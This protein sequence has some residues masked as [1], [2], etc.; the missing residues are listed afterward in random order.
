[1]DAR[2][3]AFYL[4]GG[5]PPHG[6]RTYPGCRDAAPPSRTRPV[7][8]RGRLYFASESTAWTGGL[9]FYDPHAE[10][11]TPAHAYL[12]TAGQFSDL[13]AQ[14]MY[15]PPDADLDLRAVIRDGT[16][17]LGP[18][19]YETLVCPGWLDGYPVLTFTAPWRSSQ[20]ALNAPVAAYLRHFAS[21]LVEAHRWSH[22][23]AAEY[24]AGCPGAEGTWTPEG[25]MRVLGAGRRGEV[26]RRLR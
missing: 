1:M 2:R 24:L 22:A 16:A 13:A 8:L 4:S 15:R 18:G 25:V 26:S 9:G 23:R 11:E 6:A 17:A 12:V 21:G 19:R 14:E 7:T 20:V 5:R 10:G 3:L